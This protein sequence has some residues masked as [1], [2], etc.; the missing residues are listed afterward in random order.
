MH[1]PHR[2]LCVCCV[3]ACPIRMP[4]QTHCL[5][6]CTGVKYI[7]A[8]GA[9]RL[10]CCKLVDPVWGVRM[11]C[12]ASSIAGVQGLQHLNSRT[13]TRTLPLLTLSLSL[14]LFN[15]WNICNF[16]AIKFCSV[17]R[18][19]IETMRA[20]G[21]CHPCTGSRGTAL[22]RAVIPL[23]HAQRRRKCVVMASVHARWCLDAR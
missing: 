16:T 20:W 10:C 3:Q 9:L 5:V 19:H 1:C 21:S 4:G 18:R 15:L 6:S 12:V 14:S 8:R 17:L 7:Q 2:A 23:K 22:Q 11:S 13:Q